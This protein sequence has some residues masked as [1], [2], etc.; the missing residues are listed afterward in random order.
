WIAANAKNFAPIVRP[1]PATMSKA[2]VPYGDAS[3]IMTV[4]SG[5]QR[6]REATAWWSDF[7]ARH[8]IQLG[9]GPW[10]EKR[11]VYTNAAFESKFING[12]HRVHHL[13][14]DLFMP[15]GTALHTPLDATVRSVQVEA[16]PLG[17]GGLVTLLHEPEGCPPFVTLWGHMG[18]EALER[19]K[20]GQKL[21]AGELVGHM[22]DMHEN[23]GWTPHLHFQMATDIGLCATEIIGVGEAAWLDV[24]ADVFPDAATLAGIP[25][26]AF[27]Q[28]GRTRSEI[29]ARRKEILLPNLSISYSE[30]I[31]FVRGEGVWLIDNRGRAY[32]DCFNNVCHLG[33][34]HPD[35][36]AA[37]ARQAA[38]LNTNTRYLHDNIV[39]YAERLTATLPPGL[40]VASF[41]CSGSEANSLMLRMARN[42]T[43]SHDALVLDWAYHGNTQEIIDLSPYKYKR[44]G[45]K[46]K[47]DHVFQADIPDS[48]RAPADW[49]LEEHGKRFAQ[50][51]AAQIDAMKQQG[52]KP[53]FFLA[54]SIPSVAGQV[55]F[56]EGYLK[57]VYA[58]VRAAGGLCV[59]DEVQVGFGRVGSHWWAFEMQGVVP[60]IV[61]MGKP[62]GNGHPM[63]AL[64]TTREVADSFN[65]GME[66][67]NTFA[68]NPVSCAVG[69]AVLDAIERDGLKQNA[70]DV[71][72]YLLDGFRAMQ[73]RYDVIGDVRGQGL[74]L[75][76]ELVLDRKTK[77]PATALA[78]RICDGARE[79]GVLMG[80][81]GPFDNVLK[82]RPP[83]IF[84]RANAD[85]LLCVLEDSI[86]AALR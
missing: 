58:M 47:P 69:L 84:S 48:Y 30:P 57:E 21:A 59:A 37:L 5:A 61:T 66:Y 76:V 36:V 45:G 23:G 73:K 81:E 8:H 80:T 9:V 77:V 34:T 12:Q 18:H 11:T 38:I 24:W 68:G 54:E 85:H 74:F 32:L 64:V 43:G 49:P 16:E 42:H 26:E 40:A 82:M 44:K 51:V 15:A 29:I 27:K 52:R 41:A 13:G 53:A 55:F 60:D 63:A 72:N 70:L 35:V 6:P 14:V 1:H 2:I 62:I 22:G 17:Y 56:P 33:H 50:S 39:A 7:C 71:G 3:H 46:G 75:G 25:A 86:G 79:R 20:P 28:T 31:K 4:D 83:M 10:G 19:L 78:K 67:F 65:N